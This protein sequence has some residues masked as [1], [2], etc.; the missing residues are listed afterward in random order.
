M[1]SAWFVALQKDFNTNIQCF[2]ILPDMGSSLSAWTEDLVNACDY[3]MDEKIVKMPEV[4]Q[5]ERYI[6]WCLYERWRTKRK[7]TS[8]YVRMQ[9]PLAS[10]QQFSKAGQDINGSLRALDFVIFNTSKEN[11]HDINTVPAVCVELS[12]AKMRNETSSQFRER[13]LKDIF[14]LAYLRHHFKT[15]KAFFVM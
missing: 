12:L 4:L 1:F 9:C 10:V 5:D 11:P 8:K 2:L 6:Q 15:E 7:G 13:C 14:R 3:V